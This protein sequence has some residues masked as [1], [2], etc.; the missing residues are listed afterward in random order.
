MY[1]PLNDSPLGASQPLKPFR[2]ASMRAGC[3]SQEFWTCF[4]D[5][6]S[7]GHWPETEMKRWSIMAERWRYRA[8][9]HSQDCCTILIVVRNIPVQPIRMFWHKLA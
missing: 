8:A 5:P 3:I 7:V 4:L 2:T 9:V 6:L 1:D